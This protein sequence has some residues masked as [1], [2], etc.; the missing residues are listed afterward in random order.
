MSRRKKPENLQYVNDLTRLQNRLIH[1][2]NKTEN[3][4]NLLKD[5]LTEIKN[6]TNRSNSNMLK[7]VTLINDC[8]NEGKKKE[9]CLIEVFGNLKTKGDRVNF[10]S[11]L[12]DI[13]DKKNKKKCNHMKRRIRLYANS[14][15]IKKK[16]PKKYTTENI[17]LRF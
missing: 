10:I 11:N 1:K 4:E 9:N 13:Y 16:K 14:Y 6:E 3:Q 8:I 15:P 17:K 2:K 5:I 12:C 7:F